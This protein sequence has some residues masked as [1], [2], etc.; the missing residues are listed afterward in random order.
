MLHFAYENKLNTLNANDVILRDKSQAP[1]ALKVIIP[2]LTAMYDAKSV[3]KAQETTLY[4]MILDTDDKQRTDAQYIAEIQKANKDLN[5]IKVD[6]KKVLEGIENLE[7]VSADKRIFQHQ[8]DVAVESAELFKKAAPD[9]AALLGDDATIYSACVEMVSTDA[10][11]NMKSEKVKSPEDMKTV[12]N[13]IA[14]AFNYALKQSAVRVFSFE[15]DLLTF[16]EMLSEDFT[17]EVKGTTSDKDREIIVNL[18]DTVNKWQAFMRQ[19]VY[20]FA[21]G[22]NLIKNINNRVPDLY[23][24]AKPAYVYLTPE[25]GSDVLKVIQKIDLSAG[26]ALDTFDSIKKFLKTRPRWTDAQKIKA[27]IECV[28]FVKSFLQTPFT[29]KVDLAKGKLLDKYYDAACALVYFKDK[30]LSEAYEPDVETMLYEGRVLFEA[31][32]WTAYFKRVSDKVIA[33]L[34]G[35]MTKEQEQHSANN[36]EQDERNA[37]TYVVDFADDFDTTGVNSDAKSKEEYDDKDK[38]KAD[39]SHEREVSALQQQLEDKKK[40]IE[41]LTAKV[42]QQKTDNDEAVSKT[43]ETIDKLQKKANGRSADALPGKPTVPEQD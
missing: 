23:S 31:N 37:V 11:G 16:N 7:K 8:M 22:T 25:A 13:G 17:I 32:D 5:I 38:K 2:V 34:K 35:E 6:L 30:S 14:E 26:K 28:R 40:E 39:D 4:T 24:G 36:R 21:F 33:Y 18:Q 43:T 10:D 41:E 12:D 3:L 20:G 1:A 15:K 19:P 27:V 29:E 9:A 42:A